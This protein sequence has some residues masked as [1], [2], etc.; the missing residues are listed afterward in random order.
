MSVSV[1]LNA[2]TLVG[3][4]GGSMA[5]RRSP[6]AVV[7]MAGIRA[8]RMVFSFRPSPCRFEP[9]CSAY[10]LE[11]VEVH[12]A[13]RGLWLTTRRIG[14][15]RPGGG[16]GYDPVPAKSSNSGSSDSDLKSHPHPDSLP[17]S[18]TD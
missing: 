12:G 4:G 14:R 3:H 17:V 13:M 11:A 10:G 18:L 5:L 1:R 2:L 15:C 8:Y 16:Q 6:G 9:T 7:V